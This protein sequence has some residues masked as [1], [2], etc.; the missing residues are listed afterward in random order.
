M[1]SQAPSH[2]H[3]RKSLTVG[4]SYDTAS[5]RVLTMATGGHV[6][7]VTMTTANIKESQQ[8]RVIPVST[9]EDV[10]RGGP[11]TTIREV[12]TPTSPSEPPPSLSDISTAATNGGKANIL[13][14]CGV[15]VMSSMAPTPTQKS[16]LDDSNP[17]PCGTSHSMARVVW[18]GGGMDSSMRHK[19]SKLT[20]NSQRPIDPALLKQEVQLLSFFLCLHFVSAPWIKMVHTAG[21]FC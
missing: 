11:L 6:S 3:R 1:T 10:T 12:K 7:D 4:R 14:L 5:G 2:T 9:E 15:S 8:L 18:F 17:G 20:A 21:F 16:P 13:D 19:S